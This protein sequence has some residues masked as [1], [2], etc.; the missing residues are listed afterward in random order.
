MSVLSQF[1]CCIACVSVELNYSNAK[2]FAT[3]QEAKAQTAVPAPKVKKEM[4][5]SKSAKAKASATDG[6]DKKEAMKSVVFK[7]KSPVDDA[8]PIKNQVC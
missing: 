7:G 8:C 1:V 3:E 6:G 5:K 2:Q 4:K